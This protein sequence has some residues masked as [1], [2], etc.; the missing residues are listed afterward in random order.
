MIVIAFYPIRINCLQP[1]RR[2]S[3]EKSSSCTSGRPAHDSIRPRHAPSVQLEET[4]TTS[5]SNAAPPP[6]DRPTETR[7]WRTCA[8][9][10]IHWLRRRRR[11]RCPIRLYSVRCHLRR[12][13]ERWPETMLARPNGLI[14]NEG[15]RAKG[16]AKFKRSTHNVSV[17]Q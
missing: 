6:T 1:Q 16:E 8:R 7:R 9:V 5:S 2:R 10:S 17:K 12:K 4:R 13:N 11:R 15:F 3:S 14:L